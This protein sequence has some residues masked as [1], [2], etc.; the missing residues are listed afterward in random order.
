MVFAGF[1]FR[2]FVFRLFILRG[3]V[4]R[5]VRVL[6]VVPAGEIVE[7]NAVE[8]QELTTDHDARHTILAVSFQISSERLYFLARFDV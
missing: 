4:L 3:L 8:L 7:L 2:I 1:G 5:V 6:I